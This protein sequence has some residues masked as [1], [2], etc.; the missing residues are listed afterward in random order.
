MYWN[1]IGV[2]NV[3]RSVFLAVI[4]ADLNFFPFHRWAKKMGINTKAAVNTLYPMILFPNKVFPVW[5]T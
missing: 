2:L 1:I 4:N 5:F 3:H